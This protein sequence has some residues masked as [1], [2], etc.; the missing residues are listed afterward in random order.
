LAEPTADDAQTH[1]D[2]NAIAEPRVI[3][4]AREQAWIQI[5]SPAG[6]YALTRTLEPGEVVTVPNRADLELWTGNAG[7]LD[8]IVDGTSVPVLAYAGSG[9]VRRHVSLDPERLLQAAQQR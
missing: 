4:R 5:S 1:A 2:E 7:G 6:D 8:I 3:L 9:A